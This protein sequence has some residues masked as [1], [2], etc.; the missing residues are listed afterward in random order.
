MTQAEYEQIESVDDILIK[1]LF[2]ISS[3]VPIDLLY[4]EIGVWPIR[5]VIKKRRCLYL[6]R[7]L[8]QTEDS[9]LFRFFLAQLKDPKQGDWASQVL[10][11]LKELEI[12]YELEQIQQMS[13]NK[14]SQLLTS[15]IDNLAFNWLMNKKRSRTSENA[16]GKDL[17]YTQFKMADYLCPLD[18]NISI[19][20]QKWLFK[21]RVEDID[22]KANRRWQNEDISCFSCNTN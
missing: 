15:N 6:H 21:C 10:K 22:V 17:N 13:Y 1:N 5:F 3:C 9:T 18:E 20:E 14:Y 19:N 7:I 4:L 12:Q 8:Q 11:D 16:K 2:Q